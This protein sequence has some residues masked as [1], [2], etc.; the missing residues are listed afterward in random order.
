[1][2]NLPQQVARNQYVADGVT[3][4][5]TYDFQILSANA[6]ANDIGVYV[7]L[8]GNAPNPVADVQLL[9]TA[10]TVQGAG[11]LTGGTITFQPGYTPPIS[12]TVTLLRNMSVS[13]DTDFSVAQNFNGANLDAAFER[14]VLIM[15]QYFTALQYTTLTYPVNA[16][17][18]TAYLNVLPQLP[19]NYTWVG[20]NGQVVP[21][22]LTT[23]IITIND[24]TSPFTL[25][26][27]SVTTTGAQLNYLNIASGLTGTGNIVYSI[28]A[29]LNS[30]TIVGGTFTST[31]F[32]GVTFNS[33][34]L[35]QPNI[36][37]VTNGSSAAAGSVGEFISSHVLYASSVSLTNASAVNITSISLTAGEWL[38]GGNVS[39]AFSG[40][41]NGASYIW[42]GTTSATAPDASLY[43]IVTP[44]A[45]CGGS[46]PTHLLGI[47]SPATLYLSAIANFSSGTATGCG[48]LW[49][50]RVR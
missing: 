14:V 49:A 50:L 45:T 16:I 38:V 27:T 47:S 1:M 43:N 35:N 44:G 30:P 23:D 37:G 21:F 20:M 36:V 28:G 29:T 15:Q 31:T 4:V 8:A 19:N 33:A 12:S 24:L 10:Y 11:N 17:I 9:G 39:M 18:P 25:T 41:S 3:T 13:I 40:N 6:I 34:T 32:T 48:F 5:Y 2:S 7:T 46:V 42:S 26:N 22:E